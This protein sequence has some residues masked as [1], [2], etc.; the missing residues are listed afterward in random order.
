MILFSFWWYTTNAGSDDN[1]PHSLNVW[2]MFVLK[3][4]RHINMHES[5]KKTAYPHDK[6]D[7]TASHTQK[8]V[9]IDGSRWERTSWTW[10][11]KNRKLRWFVN[12]GN[13][14]LS[15]QIF[16]CTNAPRPLCVW[17]KHFTTISSMRNEIYFLC[18]I[19]NTTRMLRFS[20]EGEINAII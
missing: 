9:S 12:P 10:Q 14:L 7:F 17:W 20:H 1:A 16:Y 5:S 6:F 3:R 13:S 2:M 11:K 18:W 15:V 8:C 19:F 4:T